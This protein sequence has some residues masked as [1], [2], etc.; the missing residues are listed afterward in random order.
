M[1]SLPSTGILPSEYCNPFADDISS[2]RDIAFMNIASVLIIFLYFDI[3]ALGLRIPSRYSSHSHDSFSNLMVRILRARI[4]LR[5]HFI[6]FTV[7]QVSVSSLLRS[8]ELSPVY[9]PMTPDPRHSSVRQT[10]L[11]QVYSSCSH[12][13]PLPLR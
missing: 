9:S 4:R 8:V 2:A 5:N 12:G 6:R 1:T 13:A 11:E 3:P 7:L 10:L